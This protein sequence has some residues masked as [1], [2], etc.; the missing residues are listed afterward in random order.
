MQRMSYAVG[1]LWPQKPKPIKKKKKKTDTLMEAADLLRFTSRFDEH[2]HG[3][4]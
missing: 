1:L 4:R 3:G 2:T